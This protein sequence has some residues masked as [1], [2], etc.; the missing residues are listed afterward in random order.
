FAF[1]ID[2]PYRSVYPTFNDHHANFGDLNLGTKSLL[3]DCELLQVAFQFRTYIPVASPQ[4]GIG[5]GHTSLEPSFLASLNLYQDTYLQGQV[6]EWIAIGGDRD[7]EGSIVH[8][9]LSLNRLWLK[10]GACQ[11]IGTTEFNGW[12]FQDGALTTFVTPDK[13]FAVKASG[14]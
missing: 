12:T 1:F 2:T 10:K 11:V 5:T 7:Y 4:N 14:E 8:Y 3:I 13:G 6:A 9:H